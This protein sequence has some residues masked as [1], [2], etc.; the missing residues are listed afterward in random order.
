LLSSNEKEA[1][2]IDLLKEGYSIREI[3]K[4]VHMSFSDI[5]E[6]KR[7]VFGESISYKKKKKKLSKVA[8]ALELFSKN[9]TPIDVAIE[10]DIDPKDVEKIYLNYLGLNGLT[11]IV[12]IHQELGN[13]LPDFINFYWSFREGGADNKKIKEILDIANR[14]PELK[15]EI[16]RLQNER[17][18]LEIQIEQKK[19]NLQYLDNQIEIATNVLSTQYSNIES[20][21]NEAN[22]LIMQLQSLKKLIKDIENGDEYNHLEKKVE[23]IL[24]KIIDDK[25]INLSLI[26]I[27][28]FEALGNDP[29]KYD[30]I[31]NYLNAFKNDNVNGKDLQ[32]KENYVFINNRNLLHE[33]DKIK[34]K[35]FKMY[36]NKIISNTIKTTII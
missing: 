19:Q 36:S 16:K 24:V 6:I 35:L 26:L 1:L 11:Q 2:V 22:Y 9:K 5:G 29:T 23:D 33:I 32:S 14:A 18:N 28:V 12:N 25:S 17:K 15:L 3:A 4:E 10:L 20:L 27:A 13:H 31:L 34:K 8:Q 7:R 30:I 21:R